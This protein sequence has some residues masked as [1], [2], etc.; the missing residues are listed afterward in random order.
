MEEFAL[1]E[2]LSKMINGYTWRR[3]TIGHSESKTYLLIGSSCNLYLKIQSLAAVESLLNEKERL[4]W[5][6]GKLPVPEVVYYGQDDS[7]EYLLITEIEGSNASEKSFEI[8]LPQLMKQ[9]AYGLR[10]V[11]D[12]HVAGCPFNQRLDS[13][14]KE[15]K[16]RVEDNLVDEENFDPH[17][18]G[19]KAK[20]LFHELLS[21]KPVKEDLVFTHGDFCLP[22]I[23]INNGKVHGF[24]DWGRAGVA[25]RYQDIALAIRSIKYNFGDEPIHAFL[26]HY[27]LT[28]LDETK[29]LYYQLMDEFF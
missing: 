20:D 12:I 16:K 7:N 19:L 17:R 28:E 23:I 4:E 14:I 22:N 1:P 21:K 27:G 5:L 10:A 29:A 2:N 26:E 15:A 25:D 13:K 6:Q 3:N 8:I 18:Q 24:I 9:L 11:H